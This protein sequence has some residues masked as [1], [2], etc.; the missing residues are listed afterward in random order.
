MGG[1]VDVGGGYGKGRK[2]FDSIKR[3]DFTQI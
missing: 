1:T 3:Q 2:I